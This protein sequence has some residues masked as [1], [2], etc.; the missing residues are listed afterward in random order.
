MVERGGEQYAI[1]AKKTLIATGGYGA[2]LDMCKVDGYTTQFCGCYVGSTTNKGDGIRMGMGAGASLC[3]FWCYRTADG[4]PD[5]LK[6]GADWTWREYDFFNGRAQ[7]LC[8]YS[9]PYPA[10]PPAYVEGQCRGQRFMVEN[11]TWQYKTQSAYAQPG[12]RF[13]A[14]FAGNIQ[15]QID[16]IKGSRYGMCENMITPA[17][18]IYFTDDEIVPLWEWKDTIPIDNEKFHTYH[19]CDTLEEL[20]DE[21]GVDRD[22][23]L[24][25]VERYN[26]IC[27]NGEDTDFGKHPSFL[28]P[29]DQPPFIAVESKPAFLWTTQGGL[30]VNG[31][32]EV[33]NEGGDSPIPNLYCGSDDCGGQVKPFNQG[34]ETLFQQAAAAALNGYIAAH[35]IIAALSEEA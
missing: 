31:N 24:A 26:E 10:L 1:K 21:I 2:N 9:C 25:T 20:A 18:R 14:I 29:I 3:N 13:Y 19:E 7:R 16:F 17:F 30:A 6:V 15:E 12:K 8:L 35:S 34:M 23:F 4:G 22:T 27:A 28:Y 5:A 32:Y 33:L 11:G